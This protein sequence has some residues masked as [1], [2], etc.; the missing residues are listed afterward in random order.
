L[1]LQLTCSDVSNSTSWNFTLF[2]PFF[3]DFMKARED[4]ETY[5]INFTTIP[6]WQF[7]TAEPVSY[8]D[9]PNAID[10]NY[11]QGKYLRD[12]SFKETQR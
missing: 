1:A 11:E 3:E 6:E 9:D 5:I 12:P 8:P 4:E 2:D 7:V 10:W